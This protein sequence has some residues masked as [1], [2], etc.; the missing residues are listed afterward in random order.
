MAGGCNEVQQYVYTVVAE[1][2]ITL[3]TR[4]LSKNT[5][6]LSLEVSDNL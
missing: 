6:V 2:G 4:F 5:I 3:D 1:P